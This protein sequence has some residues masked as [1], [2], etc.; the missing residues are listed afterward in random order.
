[1]LLAVAGLTDQ[2]IAERVTRLAKGEF[3]AFP[4]HERAVYDFAL[5]MT[6]TPSDVTDAQVEALR[7]HLGDARALDVI[8]HVAW[9]SYMTRIADAFQ[10]PLESSNVFAR[11]PRPAK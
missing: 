11:P 9:G 8:W 7:T 1:M 10:L 2:D 4:P 6:R 3:D 5:T